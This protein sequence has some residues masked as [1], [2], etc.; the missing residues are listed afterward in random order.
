MGRVVAVGYLEL[1]QKIGLSTDKIILQV[2]MGVRH[3]SH[4]GARRLLDARVGPLVKRGFVKGQEMLNYRQVSIIS[5]EEMQ[6][7]LS[8]LSRVDEYHF[9]HLGENILVS[10]VDRLSKIACG[11]VML[12]KRDGK[13]RNPSLFVTGENEP[14]VWP[15]RNVNEENPSFFVK[16]AMGLRGVTAMVLTSGKVEPGDE[17]E[18][19]PWK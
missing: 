12:F 19:V 5:L 17:V 11:S 16:C 1:D 13:Y 9:G 18:V 8:K 2:G 15:G 3:D 10:G 4:V 7:V 14:C 6:E